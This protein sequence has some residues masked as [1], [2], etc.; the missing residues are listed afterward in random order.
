MVEFRNPEKKELEKVYKLINDVFRKDYSATMQY[1]FPA[2]FTDCNLERVFI[3]EEGGEY[4]SHM[5]YQV[6][7]F[8]S[9]DGLLKISFLGGVATKAD[10]RG[11]GYADKLLKKAEE[12]MKEEGIDICF[13]SG[14]RGLYLRNGYEEVSATNFYSV[15]AK[16]HADIAIKRYESKLF[17][18]IEKIYSS[19]ERRFLRSPLD[20]SKWLGIDEW[21]EANFPQSVKICQF[22]KSFLIFEN[23]ILKAYFSFRGSMKYTIEYAG[24]RE[25]LLKGVEVFKAENGIDFSFCIPES[26]KELTDK[27]LSRNWFLK[28]KMF[29]PPY[30][31]IKI[32]NPKISLPAM[33]L[34]GYN[35]V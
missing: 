20:F 15:P 6:S 23:N 12:K 32:F 4:L 33:P 24:D 8:K 31:T 34:P 1:E 14:N 18:N 13:V 21:L 17:S 29:F 26:E 22:G 35:Y 25:A 19:E 11:K 27:A 9:E 2:L 5:G 30:H 10:S 7:E 16:K 3:A 28:E